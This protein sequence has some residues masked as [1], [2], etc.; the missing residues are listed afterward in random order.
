MLNL[1]MITLSYF[2]KAFAC[3]MKVRGAGRILN[4]SSIAAFQPGP[5]MAGYCATK[6]F[7]LSLSQAVNFELKGSGVTV[8]AVCPGVT[9]TKFHDTAD[10][11]NTFMVKLLSHASA[12][13]VAEY[14]YRKMMKG[15]ALGVYGFMNKLMTFSNRF[16]SGSAA[17]AVS[18]KILKKK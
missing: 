18:S 5:Y 15:K 17:V 1:N 12:E 9:D 14:A 10:S 11:N 6:A 8:T 13:Q 7:V 4:I 2:T 3:E 16:V